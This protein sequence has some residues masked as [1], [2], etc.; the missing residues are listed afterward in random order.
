M[1]SFFGVKLNDRIR[2]SFGANVNCL[3]SVTRASPSYSFRLNETDNWLNSI[4]NGKPFLHYVTIEVITCNCYLTWVQLVVLFHNQLIQLLG[5]NRLYI[6]LE[7]RIRF[8][9]VDFEQKIISSYIVLWMYRHRHWSFVWLIL[10]STC[11]RSMV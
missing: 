5:W 4:D 1:W 7:R 6:R 3:E 8:E 2:C 10:I 9:R 11:H